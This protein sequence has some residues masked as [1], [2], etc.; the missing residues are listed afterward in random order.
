[1]G[2]KKKNGKQREREK[3]IKSTIVFIIHKYS[4]HAIVPC[5]LYTH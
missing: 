3:K 5:E 4:F 2:V 1:M